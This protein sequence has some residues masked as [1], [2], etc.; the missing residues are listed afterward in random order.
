MSLK[1][2]T[3][4][5]S[6]PVTVAE[7]KSYLRVDG[8]DDDTIIGIMIKSAT[9]VI[10]KYIDQKLIQQTWYQYMD[11]F[12]YRTVDAWWDGVKELPVSELYT[13]EPAIKLMIGPL[14]SV[15]AFNTYADDGVAVLFDSSNYVIDTAGPFGRIALK[16]GG[17]WPTTILRKVNGIEIDFTVGMAASAS[18][19]PADL[20]QAV[21]DYVSLMY[22]NRGDEKPAMPVSIITILDQYKHYK[23][24][25]GC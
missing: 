21:L 1:L 15:N 20:R 9:A 8:S 4:P 16:L 7:A 14:V 3:A 25:N 2:K 6:D 18:N 17:V 11:R 23:A 19:L 10:E 12:P 13:P 24:S 22:E 5:T